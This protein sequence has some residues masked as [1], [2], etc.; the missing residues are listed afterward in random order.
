MTAFGG[1]C[2]NVGNS[3][4]NHNSHADRI[5]KLN[6][7]IERGGKDQNTQM[8]PVPKCGNNRFIA[9]T[10]AKTRAFAYFCPL[11][12]ISVGDS[13]NE[14]CRLFHFLNAATINGNITVN[15]NRQM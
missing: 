6:S 8:K 1:I 4:R 10:E 15:I 9:V 12:R 13:S 11:T 5:E 14:Q 3:R 7:L 2:Q